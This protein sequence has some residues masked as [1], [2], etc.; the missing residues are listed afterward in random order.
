MEIALGEQ[1]E[2]PTTTSVEVEPLHWF[3][4]ELC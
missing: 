1:I 2:P 4:A 3:T